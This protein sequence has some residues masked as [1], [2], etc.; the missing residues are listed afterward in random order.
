MWLAAW[1][2]QGVV[3]LKC[4]GGSMSWKGKG[5]DSFLDPTGGNRPAHKT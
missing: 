2:L 4:V 5:M 1:L 3:G